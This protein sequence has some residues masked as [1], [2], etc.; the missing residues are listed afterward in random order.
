MEKLEN[1]R[2]DVVFEEK[3]LR[4]RA[5]LLF[6]LGKKT[7]HQRSCGCFVCDGGECEG[8]EVLVER[9]DELRVIARPLCGL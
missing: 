2:N 6:K 3:E 7:K 9:L 5:V 4:V 1:R 8:I